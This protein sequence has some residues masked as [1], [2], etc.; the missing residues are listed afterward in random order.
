MLIEARAQVFRARLPRSIAGGERDIDRGQCM[1]IQAKG[2]AC[3]ALDAVAGNRAAEGSG[4]DGEPQAR[5]SFM[6]GQH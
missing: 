4:G 2:L 3:N 5:M 6:V 1:L